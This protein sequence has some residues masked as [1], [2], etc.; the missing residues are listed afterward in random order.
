VSTA[1]PRLEALLARSFLCARAADANAEIDAVRSRG[2][3]ELG[4]ELLSYEILVPAL[5]PMRH[6]VEAVL[7]KLVY[8]LDCRG[9]KLPHAPG[10]FASLFV[11][12]ELY[13]MHAADLIDELAKGSGLSTAQMV[14]RW[15]AASV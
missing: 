12:D 10:V 7:P 13:C 3:E 6:L 8:F 14:E 2:R 1:D 4:A 5:E 11:G 9:A 15:G